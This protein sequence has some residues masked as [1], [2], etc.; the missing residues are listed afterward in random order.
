[1]TTCVHAHHVGTC[2]NC[3]RAQLARW[4]NQLDEATKRADVSRPRTSASHGQW[5]LAYP[6]AP[7]ASAKLT[8]S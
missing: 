4:R 7:D 2:P 1:M 8:I 5:D 6:I 3:Q